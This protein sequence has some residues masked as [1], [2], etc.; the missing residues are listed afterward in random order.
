LYDI[1]CQFAVNL[2]R[3][4]AANR[5]HL[6]LAQGIEIIHSI[7]L[8]HIHCHQDSCMPRY[9]PNYIPG[10]GQVDGEVIETLWAPLN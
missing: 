1:N 4:M 5:K 6:S 2:L 9:S 3:R 10:A 7:S 8:F